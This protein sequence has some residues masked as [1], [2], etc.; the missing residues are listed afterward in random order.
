MPNFRWWEVAPA[1]E[2]APSKPIGLDWDGVD[3]LS[4]VQAIEPRFVPYAERLRASVQK[5]VEDKKED[6]NGAWGWIKDNVGGELK[7]AM[8]WTSEQINNYNERFVTPTA[9]WVYTAAREREVAPG[10]AVNPLAAWAGSKKDIDKGE[11][12]MSKLHPAARLALEFASDPLFWGTLP[13]TMGGGTLAS[14]TAKGAVLGAA[15][16]ASAAEKA[17]LVLNT[18]GRGMETIGYIPDR[19]VSTALSKTVGAAVSKLPL[20]PVSTIK[21]GKMAFEMAPLGELRRIDK[22]RRLPSDAASALRTTALHFAEEGEER[23]ALR[24]TLTHLVDGTLPDE[25]KGS[26]VRLQREALDELAPRAKEL[27]LT[28]YIERLG[29]PDDSP[30]SIAYEIGSDL[31]KAVASKWGIPL[32]PTTQQVM[33]MGNRMYRSLTQTVVWSLLWTPNYVIQN[34]VTDLLFGGPLALFAGVRAGRLAKLMGPELAPEVARSEIAQRTAAVLPSTLRK[35]DR[36]ALWKEAED[37]VGLNTAL[38]HANVGD[39]TT[40]PFM[41]L[42]GANRETGWFVNPISKFVNATD[43]ELGAADTV[44]N[45]ILNKFAKGLETVAMGPLK[46]GQALDS[47]VYRGVFERQFNRLLYENAIAN[48]DAAGLW[49]FLRQLE[50]SPTF[51]ALDPDLRQ[52]FVIK[53]QR[54][55]QPEELEQFVKQIIPLTADFVAPAAFPSRFPY[56]EQLGDRFYQRVSTFL[57]ET[58][59]KPQRWRDIER[60]T[61]G[62]FLRKD[63]PQIAV[64]QAREQANVQQSYLKALA[65]ERGFSKVDQASITG[66][67]EG[68]FGPI[69]SWLDDFERMATSKEGLTLGET[70]TMMTKHLRREWGRQA[71]ARHMQE[72]LANPDLSAGDILRQFKR[73]H[74]DTASIFT[75]VRRYEDVVGSGAARLSRLIKGGTP[76]A[77]TAWREFGEEFGLTHELGPLD[78]DDVAGSVTKLWHTVHQVIDREWTRGYAAKF[79]ALGI[80][81][82]VPVEGFFPDMVR[83]FYDMT[84]AMMNERMGVLAQFQSGE[85]AKTLT[86]AGKAFADQFRAL[87]IQARKGYALGVAKAGNEAVAFANSIMGDFYRGVNNFD[88]IARHIFPFIRWTTRAPGMVSRYVTRNPWFMPATSRWVTETEKEQLPYF[89]AW[90]PVA[91]VPFVGTILAEPLRQFAAYQMIRP[92]VGAPQIFGR[93]PVQQALSTLGVAGAFPGPIAQAAVSRLTGEPVSPT[94][95]IVPWQRALTQP[96]KV[97]GEELSALAENAGLPFSDAAK[98]L[99]LPEDLLADL[100]DLAYGKTSQNIFERDI[101]R[102]LADKGYDIAEIGKDSPEWRNATHAVM[103]RHTIRFMLPMFQPVSDEALDFTRRQAEAFMRVGVSQAEQI[104]LRREGKSPWEL[105]NRDQ[106]AQVSKIIGEDEIRRRAKITPLG[107]TEPEARLWYSVQSARALEQVKYGEMHDKLAELGLAFQAGQITGREYREQRGT[108]KET[109]YLERQEIRRTTIAQQ[110]GKGGTEFAAQLGD[111]QIREEWQ[112]LKQS[113]R[114]TLGAAAP[115]DLKPEDE[116]LELYYDIRA[117]NY[118]LPDGEIDWIAYRDAQ[119]SLLMSLPSGY[120]NYILQY[121]KRFIKDLPVEQRYERTLDEFDQYKRIPRHLGVTPQEEW[122]V[123]SVDNYV[124]TLQSRYRQL[125]LGQDSLSNEY[126]IAYLHRHGLI[127]GQQAILYMQAQKKPNPASEAFKYAHPDLMLFGLAG[128]GEYLQML[129]LEETVKARAGLRA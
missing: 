122:I 71:L 96:L 17:M 31:Q 64:Q 65:K 79:T 116:A 102:E 24:R 128:E 55:T 45:S 35:T 110:K 126:A 112:V 127:T 25:V 82:P 27:N 61:A 4:Q 15:E 10:G 42:P 95:E 1:N 12:V 87:P 129:P 19:I 11:E 30:L 91:H 57:T 119:D 63:I 80:R 53:A 16:G 108:L 58:G 39:L 43:A 20:L 18:M 33:D 75:A 113:L 60:G 47:N 7:R 78:I 84:R 76:K 41:A 90:M 117:E 99:G 111:E 125:T 100:A 14:L 105:L 94:G 104:A 73:V 107:L 62:P 52:A 69:R 56:A 46:L 54:V 26:L 49:A 74:E 44:R 48:P 72:L 121:E 3:N 85:V 59:G 93:G 123:Y 9:A 120:A 13:L 89:G 77:E 83:S 8:G 106:A 124:Q 40:G 66:E 2:P 36:L 34:F 21:G 114:T 115:T 70:Q 38:A 32:R 98:A 97:A 68:I 101:E 23:L 118:K 51:R 6:D 109:N 37:A 29:L 92:L 28:K 86:Q 67:A 50:K 5:V 88:D 103:A 81:D 22:V